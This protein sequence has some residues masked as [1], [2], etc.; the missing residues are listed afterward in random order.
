MKTLV[1]I[2]WTWVALMSSSTCSGIEIEGAGSSLSGRLISN[3][4][5]DYQSKHDTLVSYKPLGSGQ[6]IRLLT[7]RINDFALTDVALSRYET[8]LLGLVQFPLFFSG[9]THIVNLPGVASDQLILDGETL[10]SI[11]MGDIKRWTDPRIVKL[12]PTLVIA[13]L[14]ITTITRADSSGTSYIFTGYLSNQSQKWR[15]TLGNSS[16]LTWTTGKS[17]EGT[18]QVIQAVQD[19]AGSLGYVEFGAAQRAHVSTVSLQVGDELKTVSIKGIE[20]ASQQFTWRHGSLYSISPANLSG[21]VWPIVGVTYALIPKHNKQD[22]EARE[23]I[24]FFNWLIGDKNAIFADSMMVPIQDFGLI[25]QIKKKLSDL[26]R[27]KR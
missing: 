16:K 23:T 6:G 13:D 3:L 10:A 24:A 7:G 8:D 21:P 11:F 18:S 26:N 22:H 27:S 5:Q 14:P 25:D 19:T 4:A 20:L 15:E 2:M 12:N 9:I 1:W 17:V